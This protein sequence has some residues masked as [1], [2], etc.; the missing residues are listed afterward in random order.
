MRCL[1]F[2]LVF[3]LFTGCLV[4]K[5]D[6]LFAQ[7]QVL[8]LQSDSL[9]FEQRLLAAQDTVG[10]TQGQ[11]DEALRSL[12]EL[13]SQ[14]QNA[15]GVLQTVSRELDS[16]QMRHK[17]VSIERDVWRIE[18]LRATRRMERAEFVRDSL[19]IVLLKYKPAVSKPKK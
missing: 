18:G 17:E 19:Q 3:S 15:E 4:P 13:W 11:L 1:A 9:A 14:L 8:R 16:I 10:N 6:F 12:D 2:F 7:A 5:R